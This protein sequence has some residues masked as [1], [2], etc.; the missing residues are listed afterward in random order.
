MRTGSVSISAAAAA[1]C[2]HFGREKVLMDCHLINNMLIARLAC[3]FREMRTDDIETDRLMA[4][5]LQLLHARL[6]P[7]YSSRTMADR[8]TKAEA[9]AAAPSLQLVHANDGTKEFDFRKS[10]Q[11]M[12][13]S[14]RFRFARRNHHTCADGRRR[15]RV[16]RM[17]RTAARTMT[18]KV[19]N[20]H[21]RRIAIDSSSFIV[22]AAALF[23]SLVIIKALQ[24]VAL[25]LSIDRMT[26]WHSALVAARPQTDTV[27]SD[28]ASQSQTNSNDDN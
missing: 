4:R 20:G 22:N 7:V 5:L 11:T 2:S 16:R 1:H 19:V 21:S 18:A 24:C 28:G 10:E 26:K 9:Q 8:G 3:D 14:E 13:A 17:I 12:M 25:N 6:A 15:Q 23:S 27:E